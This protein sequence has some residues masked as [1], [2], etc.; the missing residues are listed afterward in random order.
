M[1]SPGHDAYP[2]HPVDFARRD[3]QVNRLRYGELIGV[4]LQIGGFANGELRLFET[5][6]SG[7]PYEWKAIA[8]GSNRS[9]NQSFLE[10]EYTEDIVLDGA[11]GLAMNALGSVRENGID[12]ESIGVGT[13]DADAGSY[14]ELTTAEIREYLEDEGLLG[15]SAE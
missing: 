3:A 9:D 6:P 12:P 11:I 7:T 5:D 14:R 15:E 2:R 10:T 1:A 13:V 8:I 4:A